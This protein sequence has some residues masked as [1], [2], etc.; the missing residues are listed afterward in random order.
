MSTF[1]EKQTPLLIG[2]VGFAHH[3]K[4]TAANFFKTIGFTEF[5]FADALKLVVMDMFGFTYN[6]CYDTKL[7]EQ[8]DEFWGIT[9]REAL[10]S[11]GELNAEKL[12]ELMP[13]LNLGEFGRIW[14][15]RFEREYSTKEWNRKC[16]VVSDVRHE[17]EARSIKKLGGYILRIHNSRIKMTEN[18]RKS[19]S[20]QRIKDIRFDGIINNDGSMIDL[21]KNVTS[22]YNSIIANPNLNSNYENYVDKNKNIFVTQLD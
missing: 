15:R 18:F 6:Q 22:I 3:G 21:Y 14:I 12:K 1:E 2:I 5:A 19:A 4:S 16:I 11:V 13:N 17:N 10:I 8:I 9:P 7:K 20:E